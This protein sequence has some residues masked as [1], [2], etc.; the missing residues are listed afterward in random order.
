MSA[1]GTSVPVASHVGV[2]AVKVLAWYVVDFPAVSASG[3][4]RP[5]EVAQLVGTGRWRLPGPRRDL[6]LQTYGDKV[7]DD[8]L[9]NM[10]H[11]VLETSSGVGLIHSL[12]EANDDLREVAGRQD[13]GG[14]ELTDARVSLWNVGIGLVALVYDLPSEEWRDRPSLTSGTRE[15]I[16]SRARDVQKLMQALVGRSTPGLAACADRLSVLWGNPNYLVQ[17][18]TDVSADARKIIANTITADGVDCPLEAYPASLVRVGL[19]CSVVSHDLDDGAADL[20][21]RLGGVHQVCWA[22]ALLHDARLAKEVAHVG[23]GESTPSISDLGRQA[24]RILREYHQVRSFRMLYSSVEAHLG[25]SA[26][27]VW[28]VLEEAWRFQQVLAVLDDRLD[29][30]RAIHQQLFTTVSDY[31]SRVLNELV[32]AFTFL[33]IFGIILTALS[34]GVLPSIA[35]QVAPLAVIVVT[36]MLNGAAYLIFRRKVNKNR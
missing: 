35:Q 24:D 28:T 15:A 31:R 2:V 16:Y 4:W 30:V 25:P 33:N 6:P 29:F 19:H 13:D 32:S 8:L 26:K 36:L 17:V 9:A 7:L 11:A 5:E 12:A 20:L 21:I 27:V 34:F 3:R 14:W 22:I 18:D 23:P 1:D 10:P